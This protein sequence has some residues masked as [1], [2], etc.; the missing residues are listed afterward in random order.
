MRLAAGR[1]G[2]RGIRS[3]SPKRARSS[4]CPPGFPDPD[5]FDHFAH[6]DRRLLTLPVLPEPSL[7]SRASARNRRWSRIPVNFL[8]GDN[9][10]DYPRHLVR[11]RHGHKHSRLPPREAIQPRAFFDRFA[12]EPVE[13]RHSPNNQQAPDVTLTRLRYSTETLF[14]PGGMLPRNEAKPGRKV[15]APAE[16]RQF[17]SKRFDC[18]RRN[19]AYPRDCL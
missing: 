2:V 19:W 9:R 3:I 11:K 14:T 8:P 6:A 4:G 13:P 16:C 1:Y 18:E 7:S 12:S 15:T 17:R 5:L 10:P